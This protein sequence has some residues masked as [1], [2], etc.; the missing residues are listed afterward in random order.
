VQEEKRTMDR[1][2]VHLTV[3]LQQAAA[4]LAGYTKGDPRAEAAQ[5]ITHSFIDV[6]CVDH[7]IELLQATAARSVALRPNVP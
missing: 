6:A 4:D 2:L 3:A 7:A 1:M 5:E